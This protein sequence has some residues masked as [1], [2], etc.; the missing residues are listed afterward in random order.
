M[1]QNIIQI[2]SHYL[3]ID[4][5]CRLKRILNLDIH[6]YFKNIRIFNYEQRHY[7]LMLSLY[8]PNFTIAKWSIVIENMK[9]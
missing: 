4:D 1:N 5:F 8:C 9:N 7:Y 3:D 6:F 2:V